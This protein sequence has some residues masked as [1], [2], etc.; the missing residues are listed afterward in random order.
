MR[1][2]ILGFAAFGLVLAASCGSSKG[3]SPS[4][5]SD[6]GSDS[7][8]GSGSSTGSS[9]GGSGGSSSGGS[10]S[11]S[12]GSG[13]S[14]GTTAGDS[15][16]FP[17]AGNPDGSCK[18]LPLPSEA[19]LV[20]T[21]KPTTVVGTGTPAS[22][23]FDALNT[24]VTKGGIIT[25]DCGLGSRHDPRHGDAPAAH[26]EGQCSPPFTSSS[27]A[28]TW[29]PST[30]RAR[31]ASCR[32]S[33][34][35]GARTRTRSRCSA[36]GSSTARR[37]PR[38]KI[39]ACPPAGGISN[40]QCSTGYDDGQGGALYM[41]D[42]NLRVI[43]SIFENNQAALLGP[44]TG[45]GAHYLFGTGAPSYIVNSS[46]LNNTASNAGGV[47][48]LWAGAFI[49]N[50]LFEGNS[51]VGTGAN[52]NNAADCTCDNGNNDNQIG[53]GG[54]GGAIYKDGGD[55]VNL[56]ICGTEIKGNTANE[57]GPAVFLTADG[58]AA[59]LIIDD[60]VI[61]GNSTPIPYWQ[62]CTDISTDNPH[63]ERRRHVLAPTDRDD[64]LQLH[65]GSV[66]DDVQFVGLLRGARR[67]HCE[68]PAPRGFTRY[69]TTSCDTSRA[70]AP[71]SNAFG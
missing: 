71:S 70:K 42:G 31:S 16:A 52:N 39:P 3:G 59:E 51:A 6:A 23:T 37:P 25:F 24:A 61:T 56:T 54:N 9:S 20:D 48:M 17:P 43:D 69:R 64:V 22:C 55:G 19:Q 4:D 32:G 62:W 34:I 47:G 5:D 13:S 11:G 2:S 1:L 21:S 58:S 27:T 49:F 53:S 66:H 36:S 12:S 10:S 67:S 15:G 68:P 46:F 65:R 30:V 35:R 8:A 40:T 63:T 38:E 33:T 57:F 14:S 44:D 29:S 45:G 60:S 7:G 41:Q 26:F 18:T 50:S 28:A